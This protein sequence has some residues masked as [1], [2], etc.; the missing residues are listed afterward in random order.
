MPTSHNKQYNSFNQKQ[1]S[2]NEKMVYELYMQMNHMQRKLD[3]VNNLFIAF[4]RGKIDHKVLAKF[5]VD[6]MANEEYGKN[7]SQS[8]GIEFDKRANEKAELA[9]KVAPLASLIKEISDE[10]LNDEPIPELEDDPA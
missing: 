2:K 3:E 8:I 7:L 10:Q 9:K 5:F 4:A 1:P 6:D